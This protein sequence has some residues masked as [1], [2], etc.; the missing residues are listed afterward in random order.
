MLRIAGLQRAAVH[1]ADACLCASP[2][3]QLDRLLLQ[4]AAPAAEAEAD[5]DE[6]APEDDA[7]AGQGLDLSMAKKKKK[8]KP[9]ART[10]EEFGAM[11]EDVESMPAE[12][13]SL[14]PM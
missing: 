3:L 10:D 13:M 14:L 11:V 6:V 9:K 8:K 7:E 1:S 12:G 5:G 2:L 4:D